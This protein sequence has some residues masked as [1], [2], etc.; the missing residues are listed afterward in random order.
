MTVA[1]GILAGAVLDEQTLIE[2]VRTRRWFGAKAQ[3]VTHARV[4]DGAV[5]RD[6]PP[7]LVHAL[8]E[9]RFHTGPHELYQLLL[10]V[11]AAGEQCPD[12]VIVQ[13]AGWMVY[14]AL[15]DPAL[16]TELVDLMRN[17]RS[18]EAGDGTLEFHATGAVELTGLP[19]PRAAGVEQSNT[20]VAFG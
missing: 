11:R 18:F 3:E 16:A 14:D 7:L 20:S 17:E 2:F 8:A 9:I 6:E 19:L 13:G 15:G 5:L 10:G 4:L 1:D 12:H